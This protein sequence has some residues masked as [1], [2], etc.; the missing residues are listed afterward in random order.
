MTK[1]ENSKLKEKCNKIKTSITNNKDVIEVILSV[2]TILVTIF[3][4]YF[5]Q[6]ISKESNAI[7]KK[8]QP[9]V[10]EIFGGQEEMNYKIGEINLP[11]KS[12]MLRVNQGVVN[13]IK[14]IE[15]NGTDLKILSQPGYD[16]I[17]QLQTNNYV[18]SMKVEQNYTDLT[19]PIIYDYFFLYI[20]S[21][22]GLN[23]LDL[24]YTKIDVGNNSVEEPE[25]I[26]KLDL[27]QNNT[28]MKEDLGYQEMLDVYRKLQDKIS[29]LPQNDMEV[30]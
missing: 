20:K 30:Y 22:D 12:P 1:R 29:E 16:F 13:I 11:C 8:Q 19:R 26:T 7:N 27:L 18:M 2:I 10:Y 6:N 21:G 14:I 23:H 28:E 15:Y 17:E 3:I 9:L 5:A 4:A 25:I 24:V